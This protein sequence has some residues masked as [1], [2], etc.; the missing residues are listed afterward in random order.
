MQNDLLNPSFVHQKLPVPK[1]LFF[2]DNLQLPKI[3]LPL[4]DLLTLLHHRQQVFAVQFRLLQVVLC[5]TL[6]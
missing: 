4:H 1:N 6:V 2:N 3:C 5:Q